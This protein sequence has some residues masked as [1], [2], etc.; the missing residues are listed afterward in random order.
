MSTARMNWAF[1]DSSLFSGF[2]ELDNLVGQLTVGG[3][4]CVGFRH[5]AVMWARDVALDKGS[6]ALRLRREMAGKTG[7]TSAVR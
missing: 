1:S 7:V 4:D 6:V 2:D 3:I 5:V